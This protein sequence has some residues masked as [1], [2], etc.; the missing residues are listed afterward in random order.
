MQLTDVFLNLGED[1][2][3]KVV[4]SISIGK[5][6][7]Y[8][9]YERF[10]LRTHASK[11]N[12]ENL[13]KITPKLWERLQERSEEYATDLSQAILVSHLDL[14]IAVLNFL[15]VPHEEG[16]FAKDLD[17]APYLTEGWRE[18]TYEEFKSKFPPSVV[19]FYINHLALEMGKAED[20]FLPAIA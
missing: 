3:S 10:K 20:S 9:L 7:T 8:Q 16:F 17:A 11:L 2:F 13:R 12:T 6:K 4:R 1:H 5:L 15:G 14:I 18:R 19:L